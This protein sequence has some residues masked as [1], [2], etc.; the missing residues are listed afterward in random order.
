MLV[1]CLNLDG[2]YLEIEGFQNDYVMLNFLI[3]LFDV[4][5]NYKFR[6]MGYYC[7]FNVFGVQYDR[8]I[9]DM[10]LEGKCCF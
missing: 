9:F 3:F 4:C 7:F 8:K 10:F 1:Q 2:K 6:M 5:K